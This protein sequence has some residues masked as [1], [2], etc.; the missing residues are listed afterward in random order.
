[1][2]RLVRRA[3][4]GLEALARKPATRYLAAVLMSVAK[5]FQTRRSHRIWYDSRGWWTNRQRGATF[6]SPTIHSG[7]LDGLSDQ[8]TD[9]WCPS[10]PLKP[11]DVVI[12][13]GAGVGDHVL[14]FSR[15]VGPTGRVLAIE[16]HPQT[17]HC[18][19]LTVEANGLANTRVFNEAAWDE[20]ST[21]QISDVD[22]HE[23]NVVGTGTGSVV[24]RAR[25]VDAMLAPLNLAKVDLIKMNV[26]GA[27]LNALAGM[28]DTL[29]KTSAI[30]VSCHDFL[31]IAPDDP[32]RTKVRVVAFL[33]AAG[34]V[35]TQRPDAPFSFARDYV[36][37]QR[38]GQGVPGTIPEVRKNR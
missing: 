30:V 8:V 20:E 25:P 21:L 12:D 28:P 22:A 18:L 32:R 10:T 15:R 38:A 37:G 4:S 35:V 1:M 24:V 26:E 6:F 27:E 13:I 31:A 16:A 14:V 34:F 23:G 5:T 7:T 36:Y 17:A 19:Q 2:H 9:F 3:S 33:E 11:G 29:A